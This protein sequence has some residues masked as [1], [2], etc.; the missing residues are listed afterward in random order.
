MVSSDVLDPAYARGVHRLRRMCRA[1]G[2][3]PSSCHLSQKVTDISDQPISR[4]AFFDVW[5]GHVN[6]LRV[7]IKAPHMH[8]SRINAI[9]MVGRFRRL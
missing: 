1:T 4:L 9:K 2:C 5:T 6:G 3:A 7:T 8:G